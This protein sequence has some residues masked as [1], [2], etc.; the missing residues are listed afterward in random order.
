[1][2]D[3]TK[4]IKELIKEKGLSQSEVAKKLGI[5][6]QN[7]SDKLNRHTNFTMS[8]LSELD[9]ALNGIDYKYIFTGQRDYPKNDSKNDEKDI[10][11]D[12]LV[13]KIKR[14]EGKYRDTEYLPKVA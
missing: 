13:E 1:M 11:I 5:S 3:I 4:R 6:S 12:S 14:L 7:L 2:S 9:N 10:I 8:F